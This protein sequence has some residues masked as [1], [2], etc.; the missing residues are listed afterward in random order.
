MDPR[1]LFIIKAI[2]AQRDLAFSNWASAWADLQVANA[3]VAELELKLSL[4][5]A[6]AGTDGPA[7]KDGADA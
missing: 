5:G 6:K 1:T 7:A 4:A 3:K 2:E